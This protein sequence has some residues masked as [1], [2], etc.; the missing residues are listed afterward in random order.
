[1]KLEGSISCLHLGN[2]IDL[3]WGPWLKKKLLLSISIFLLPFTF[4]FLATYERTDIKLYCAIWQQWN[5]LDT[6]YWIILFRLRGKIL[7]FK[8]IPI[9]FFF[10]GILLQRQGKRSLFTFKLIVI[11]EQFI[12]IWNSKNCKRF[13]FYVVENVNKYW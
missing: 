4:F 7:I 8:K 13:F 10:R 3:E 12:Y 5:V 1:M 11:F 2:S 6:M 9:R